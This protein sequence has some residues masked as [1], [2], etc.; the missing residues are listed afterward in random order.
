MSDKFT[1]FCPKSLI[2]K[3]AGHDYCEEYDTYVR[4]YH[5]YSEFLMKSINK[6]NFR[7][8]YLFYLFLMATVTTEI[9]SIFLF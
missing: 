1:E 8:L 6:Y 9:V 5:Y 2:F 3:T 4:E 7:N